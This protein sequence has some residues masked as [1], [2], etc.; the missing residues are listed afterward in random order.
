MFF[1]RAGRMIDDDLRREIAC[2]LGTQHSHMHCHNKTRLR[3]LRLRNPF[4][5][6]PLSYPSKKSKNNQCCPV[7]LKYVSILPPSQDLG[8]TCEKIIYSHKSHKNTISLISRR[9]WGL[10]PHDT[11]SNL[12]PTLTLLYRLPLHI[13]ATVPL[14]ESKTTA[15]LYM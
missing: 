5:F 15:S 7:C 12:C 13:V 4:S 14:P 6:L 9:R 8:I 3:L 2:W 1:I 11:P 10:K